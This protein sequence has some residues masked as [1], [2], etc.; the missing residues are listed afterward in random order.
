M[1]N[2]RIN[3]ESRT[4]NSPCPWELLSSHLF[5]AGIFYPDTL[6]L[7]RVLPV[8]VLLVFSSS[9]AEQAGHDVHSLPRCAELLQPRSVRD[10]RDS[11]TSIRG[12]G[13]SLCNA[14]CY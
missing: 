12:W 13:K 11:S 1:Q 7:W 3:S 9:S 5:R 8:F 4:I 2:G 6:L 10:G 14:S